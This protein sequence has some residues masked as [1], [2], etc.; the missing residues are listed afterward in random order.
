M[1]TQV[2]NKRKSELLASQELMLNQAQEAQIKLTDAQE[3]TFKNATAEVNDIDVTL[4]RMAAIAKSKA[5]VNAP[6]SQLALFP[7][8]TKSGKKQFSA[9]YEE[10][11]WNM[12]KSRNFKNSALGEGGTTDGG[13]LVPITVDGTITPLA[14]Y[15]SAMRKLA[16]VISTTMD[17]KLPAEASRSAAVA[18]AESR[19]SNNPFGG[20]SPSFSTVTLSAFMAGTVVPVTFELA[21]DVPA[22]QG[23]LEGDILRGITNYEE[24]KFINGSGT[25]EP[26]GILNG[27]S[28]V[29]TVSLTA[30][31]ALDLT[32]FLP[33][34][35]Y[36]NASWL[37]HRR[38][39]IAFRKAQIAASQFQTYFTDDGQGNERLFGY[40]IVYSSQMPVYAASPSVTGAVAFGDFATAAVIGDRGGSAIA[41]K[42][43]DQV[44]ALNGVIDV[45]GY[46]RTDQRIRVPEAVVIGDVNG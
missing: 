25:G 32:G 27:A 28:V 15:E 21:Q 12:F 31:T 20:V 10:A 39:G 37:M 45:L 35:Y 11:F 33:A 29:Q 46:R 9:E 36:D 16:T 1:D 4:S 34:A 24:A 8:E 42:I 18:K 43:L 14:P 3:D 40:P 22:L 41:I 17:I 6:T 7:K 26:M 23:F 5:E 13:Y 30:A 44:N 38:T 2:L 19:T